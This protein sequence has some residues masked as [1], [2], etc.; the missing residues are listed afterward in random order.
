MGRDETRRVVEGYLEGHSEEWLAEGVELHDAT[1]PEGVR[2]RRQVTSLIHRFYAEVFGG[3]T[4]DALR[5][6]LDEDRAVA[7]W[8]LRGRHVGSLVGE[9]PTG[10]SVTLP[11]ACAYDVAGG[12]I[13]RLRLYYDGTSLLA[14]LAAVPIEV[15]QPGV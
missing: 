13:V 1:R 7:E 3:A 15:A 8:I 6:T 9:T 12:E 2:G 4:A 11:M 14:Q 10:R 5:L